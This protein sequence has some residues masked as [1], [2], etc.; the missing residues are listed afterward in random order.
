M[1]ATRVAVVTGA[2]SGLGLGL[3]SRLAQR[4]MHVV[5]ADVN[6][7]G[8]ALA[9]REL[10]GRGGSPLAVPTDVTKQ[11]AMQNLVDR[12]MEIFG[13]VDIVCLNAGVSMRGRAWELS[14]ADWRWVY[15]VNV[16]GVVYGIQGF[17]PALMRQNTG[18]VIITA[19]NS[20]ITTLTGVAPYVSSKHAVLSIAETLQH[21]L[22]EVGSDVGVSVVLP[23]AIRSAMA[24]A[25]RNR[26]RDYGSAEVSPDVLA[27]SR[28]FLKRF[29]ADPYDMAEQVLR[30]ALEEHR[31]CIF[32]DPADS[33]ML[34]ARTDA[35][36]E[37]QLPEVAALVAK[38][39]R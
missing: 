23:G 19:S 32:T 11:E 6:A 13:R 27:A 3:A 38:E 33:S 12:T 16:F 37:G 9:E 22:Y 35:L 4:G 39:V 30:G 10:R 5:I 1:D 31:F 20:A 17:V 21:D 15:D 28:D 34:T 14:T 24:D 18:R 36:R 2:A 8:L 25:I 7:D 26:P 29:G